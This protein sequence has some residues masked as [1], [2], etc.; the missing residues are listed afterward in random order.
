MILSRILKIF[1]LKKK[2]NNQSYPNLA[3]TKVVADILTLDGRVI[4]EGISLSQADC[5]MSNRKNVKIKTYS[6]EV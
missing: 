6:K 4:F 3:K 2:K 1:S 5:I